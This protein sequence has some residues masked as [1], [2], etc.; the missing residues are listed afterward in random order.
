VLP[1]LREASRA[2][3][4]LWRSATG[5][6]NAADPTGSPAPSAMQLGE[7][8]QGVHRALIALAGLS[9]GSADSDA[10]KPDGVVVTA[11][12]I[13]EAIQRLS[14]ASL[15]LHHAARRL[16]AGVGADHWAAA[17]E[18]LDQVIEDL[19]HMAFS[20]PG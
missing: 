20:S 6:S 15:E 1:L 5:Y 12:V 10:P 7:A 17:V 18:A 9:Y 13:D 14:R 4:S 3:D 16:P 11:A 2:I 19:R 8:S